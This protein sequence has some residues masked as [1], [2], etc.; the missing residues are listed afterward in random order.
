MPT[1]GSVFTPQV[2]VGLGSQYDYGVAISYTFPSFAS[3]WGSQPVTSDYC[4]IR[5]YEDFEPGCNQPD[6]Q[7]SS[8]GRYAQF[9]L[10]LV[11][12]GT[13][14]N[15][16]GHYT[17]PNP[18]RNHLL[19]TPF[20]QG[21]AGYVWR[22]WIDIGP[23]IDL[24]DFVVVNTPTTTIDIY[25][26]CN[27]GTLVPKTIAVT[28]LPSNVSFNATTN[29][30]TIGAGASNGSTAITVTVTNYV[31]QS[32][33]KTVNMII[34][35]AADALTIDGSSYGTG[36]ITT[37]KPRDILV[38]ALFESGGQAIAA[39]TDTAGLLWQKRGW[40]PSTAIGGQLMP[41]IELWYAR[42]NNAVTNNTLTIIRGDGST[43][44]QGISLLAIN[45][46]N[47]VTP[48]DPD[49][50]LIIGGLEQ[51]SAT[52]GGTTT[53][54]TTNAYSTT[55][56]KTISLAMIQG[57]LSSPGAFTPPSGFTLIGSPSG[58]S[59]VSYKVNSS[60]VSGATATYSWA[61]TTTGKGM[62]M[63]VDALQG[64][65]GA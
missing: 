54:L 47:M 6:N 10:G 42:A 59:A 1:G 24:T 22:D 14:R 40:K 25:Y 55:N 5:K 18:G 13:T 17:M 21:C 2:A 61:N 58:A 46:A 41:G 44:A 34:Q 65:L 60:P 36:I 35:A 39:V 48:F 64:Q 12:N 4:E 16:S 45:G 30:I 62:I 23:R 43:S 50:S 57:Y 49:S 20:A 3:L 33:S 11:W 38:A 53:T 9:P 8:T 56:T 15:L 32:A 27:C 51:C 26:V 29:L 28:G 31:G 63:V 37:T 7:S 52:V 19:C